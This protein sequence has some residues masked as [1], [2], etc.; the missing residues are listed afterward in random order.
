MNASSASGKRAQPFFRALALLAV[1]AAG[2]SCHAPEQGAATA[3]GYRACE[4]II[5]ALAD[6]HAAQGKYPARLEELVPRYLERV[7]GPV[8]IP[9]LSSIEYEALGVDNYHLEFRYGGVNYCGY[10]P[11]PDAGWACSGGH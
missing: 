9:L 5:S 8:D 2:A 7:P 10:R 3:S 6:Y 1:S 4:P 11:G